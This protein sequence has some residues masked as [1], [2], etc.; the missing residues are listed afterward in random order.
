MTAPQI[1]G[2]YILSFTIFLAVIVE[3]IYYFFNGVSEFIDDHENFNKDVGMLSCT[4]SDSL[5][6]AIFVLMTLTMYY[7]YLGLY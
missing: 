5:V 4:F 3:L 2:F 1:L 7:L 6:R